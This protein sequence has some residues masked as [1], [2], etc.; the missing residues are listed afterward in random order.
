[1][2]NARDLISPMS[3]LYGALRQAYDFFNTEL[4]GDM[5]PPCLITLQRKGGKKRRTFGFFASRR[6]G[7]VGG[8]TTDEIALNPRHFRHRSFFEVMSTLVHEMTHLWQFHQGKPSRSGYHNREW[9]QKMLWLGLCPSNTGQPGGHMVGQ[10]MTHFI[11]GGGRFE[12]AAKKL[13]EAD[14]NIAWFDIDG[15]VTLPTGPD[16]LEHPVPSGNRAKFVCPDCGDQ[17]WGKPSLNLI[18]GD[19]E[20]GMSRS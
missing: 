9:A 16:D 12:V 13:L 8:S 14:V 20:Q 2:H 3:E 1:M 11:V 6:F 5:L 15:V 4:F 10:Q 17:A 18:C 7:N 19:C